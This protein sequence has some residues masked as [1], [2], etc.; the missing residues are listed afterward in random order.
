M[1][2]ITKFL[3]FNAIFEKD[4]REEVVRQALTHAHK[5]SIPVRR[6]LEDVV[7]KCCGKVGRSQRPPKPELV[8][9]GS[10]S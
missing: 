7:E 6:R 3:W 4:F 1:P 2:K 9:S 10:W 8:E 5:A